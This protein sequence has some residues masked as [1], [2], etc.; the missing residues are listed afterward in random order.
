MV[1]DQTQFFEMCWSYIALHFQLTNGGPRLSFGGTSTAA[2]KF[3]AIFDDEILSGFSIGGIYQ[4]FDISS[5]SLSPKLRN[6]GYGQKVIQ[7][8]N[9]ESDKQILL[10]V[11][12]PEDEIK[13]RR[14]EFYKRYG[15]ELNLHEYAHPPYEGEEWVDLLVM[16]QSSKISK[17]QLDRFKKENFP[18]I[19]FKLY[20]ADN[21]Y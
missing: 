6:G 3:E 13:K 20:R 14:I 4:I 1:N 21:P 12:K 2:F 17:E 8:F 18:I 7:Q 9:D 16:T 15:F 10:E 11:E 5:I 19:H